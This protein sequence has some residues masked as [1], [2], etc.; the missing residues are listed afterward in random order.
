MKATLEFDLPEEFEEF[1]DAMRQNNPVMALM[2]LSDMLGAIEAYAVQQ[3]NVSLVELVTMHR[4]TA[5]AFR[6]GTRKSS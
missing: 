5:R 1:Q 2:E 3:H 4:A 6:D